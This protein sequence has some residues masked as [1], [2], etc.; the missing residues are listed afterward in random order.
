VAW[1]EAAALRQHH[2][3]ARVETRVDDAAAARAGSAG[4]PVAA[5]GSEADVVPE[6]AG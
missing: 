6:V 4:S 3:P 1:V 2:P 5:H